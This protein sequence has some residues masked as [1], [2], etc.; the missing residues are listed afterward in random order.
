MK[1]FKTHNGPFRIAAVLTA[2]LLFFNVFAPMA[3]WSSP[4]KTARPSTAN[5]PDESS[6]DKRRL[7][8]YALPQEAIFNEH[9]RENQSCPDR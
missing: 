8:R 2:I 1:S 4:S 6:G 3:A 5:Q 7:L 9:Q